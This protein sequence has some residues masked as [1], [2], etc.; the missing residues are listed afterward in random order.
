MADTV[1]TTYSLTKPE[2]GASDGTWGTK[3]N[4]NL[5][6]IDD[7]FDGTTQVKPNLELG[8]W[9]VGGSIVLSTAA[10]LNLLDG[11]T[12]TLTNL[13]SLTATVA[14]LNYCDG[15]TS[16]IQTQLDA[17]QA[18]DADLTA[19]AGLSTTGLVVRNGSGSATTRSIVAGN[20]TTVANGAGLS[21]N[22]A[23]SVTFCSSAEARAGTEA[24]KA[25]A[26]AAFSA[27]ALGMGQTWQDVTGS[28]AGSTTYQNLTGRPIMVAVTDNQGSTPTFQVSTDAATWVTIGVVGGNSEHSFSFIVPNNHYYRVNGALSATYWAELR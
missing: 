16:N 25:M 9:Q 7:L 21:G 18:S 23:V 17:K 19:F 8:K 13:N 15:V 14:E 1:T 27:A 4:T 12:Y 24:A 5:D 10:E 11:V 22:P 2:V 20:G 3:L 6:T 28:R 26:P